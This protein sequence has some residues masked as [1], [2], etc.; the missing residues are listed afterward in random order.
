MYV[1]ISGMIKDV[2]ILY[3][4]VM[5]NHHNQISDDQI[6]VGSQ[7]IGCSRD[8]SRS[9]PWVQLCCVN[10]VS[11]KY[12]CWIRVQLTG[13]LVSGSV[14]HSGNIIG[15]KSMYD[16]RFLCVFGQLISKGA[17]SSSSS[18]S[19]PPAELSHA[20]YKKNTIELNK[21]NKVS[22]VVCG[23][24]GHFQTSITPLHEATGKLSPVCHSY[25]LQAYK[26]IG[27]H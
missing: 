6:L 7:S 1:I 20:G 4:V 16:N 9:R 5:V 13:R 14:S 26:I 25:Q 19:P 12:E 15:A 23:S 2:S 27:K 8:H 22:C 18:S 10:Q 17:F 21:Q 3:V 24:P 11:V